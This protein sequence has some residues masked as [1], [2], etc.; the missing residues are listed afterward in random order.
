M[1]K[2]VYQEFNSDAVKK[3]ALGGFPKYGVCSNA[4]GIVETIIATDSET[5]Y[6]EII[7]LLSKESTTSFSHLKKAFLLPKSPI[8]IDR[9]RAA[10]KEHN[11]TLTNDSNTA[12][13]IISHDEFYN[14]FKNGEN[15]HTSCMMGKLW[16]YETFDKTVGWARSKEYCKTQ[17]NNIIYDSKCSEWFNIYNTNSYETLYDSW[18]LTGMA[19]NIAYRIKDEFLPVVNV[20]TI[21]H[22]SANK[23]ILTEGLMKDLITQIGSHNDEDVSL[24]GKILPTVDYKT[25]Y[26]LLWAF[27]NEIDANLYKFNRNKDVIYWKEQAQLEDYSYKSAEDMILWL[28]E[29]SL[30]DETNFRYLERIVRKE[31]R[32]DNRNLYVFKIQVK[33][34]Y[35]KYLKTK[36]K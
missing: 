30:L 20:D 21:L 1:S 32:I 3:F 5:T 17:G 15:I 13:F 9:I 35:R 18:M 26:H 7:D 22:T 23:Q 8:S 19:V 12:E 4:N 10:L 16:N 11:I 34:E 2:N 27:A 6:D 36:K 29:E 14:H 24:A 28:D 33:P 31:I 25:N